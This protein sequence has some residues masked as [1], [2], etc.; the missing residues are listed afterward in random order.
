MTTKSVCP[1]IPQ[2]DLPRERILTHGAAVCSTTELLAAC[3][4]TGVAGEDA[5][6]LAARLLKDFGSLDEL[7]TAPHSALIACHGLGG[8]KVCR[9]LAM[10]ELAM[11]QAEQ[12]MQS[13]DV[14]TDVQAVCRYL[15]RRIGHARREIFGCLYLD[16]RHRLLVWEALFYGSVNRAHV[17]TREVLQRGLELN[18]AAVILSHNHPSG[19]AEPSQADINLTTELV[20]LLKRVDIEVLDHVVVSPNGTTSFATRGLM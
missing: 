14:F 12:R 11:R 7:L 9:L 15:Q 19:N 17:H 5:I 18:A 8:A 13:Q 3:L 6:A 20:D 16:S 10:H 4:G 1:T 2:A